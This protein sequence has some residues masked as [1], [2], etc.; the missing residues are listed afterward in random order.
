MTRGPLAGLRVVE[1]AGQG[2]APFAA[3]LLAD[4]GAEV[5]RVDRIPAD[6]SAAELAR[7]DL[8]NRGRRSVAVDLKRPGG[9]DVVLRL[10]AGADVLLEGFRP[11]VAERLGIGPDACHAVTPT[12]VYGRAT[13]WGQTGPLRNA[14]AH[15]IN[16]IA[17]A[18]A[19][20]PIGSPGG[21]PVPPLALVG[22][23][24]GGGML[25]AFGVLA[26]LTEA[27][28]CGRG[29]VVDASILD[30]AALL[31]TAIWTFVHRG[32]WAPERGSNL[33]DGGAPFYR[34]YETRDHQ[35]IA[36]GPLE[37]HFYEELLS[38]V[39]LED[40]DADGQYRRDDW[41]RISDRLAEA[42]ARRTRA[43]WVEALE[44]T[45]VCFAPV[46]TM[47]EAPTHPHNVSR[48]TFVEIDGAV[49]PAPAPRFSR[50][51][52][53]KPAPSP[54]PG[55]HSRAILRDTGYSDLEIDGL[56][57]RQVIS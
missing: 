48:E 3:M 56:L 53:Q 54:R 41:P 21:P 40:V 44:A 30:G 43:E 37:P 15:D 23:F 14:A 42:F 12:L 10:V 20:H 55:E 11:G 32:E 1:I 57:R 24:G 17:L 2:P 49:Q 19:L 26:A 35:W 34:T 4:L 29:Q 33:L 13:G 9:A 22:D 39:G 16:Y 27:R 8:L 36:V 31:T 45:D 50:T 5:I 18:G 46:L 51:P 6:E 7:S 52:A 38:R 25:L 47:Q 28:V